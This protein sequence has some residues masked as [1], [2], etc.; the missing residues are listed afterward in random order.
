MWERPWTIH[1]MRRGSKNWTLAADAGVS[2]HDCVYVLYSRVLVTAEK[3]GAGP[4][5]IC[6][7]VFYVVKRSVQI[8]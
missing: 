2:V 8:P 6:K 4:P 1:E 3:E 7:V 5:F